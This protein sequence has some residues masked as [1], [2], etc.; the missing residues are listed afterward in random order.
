MGVIVTSISHIITSGEKGYIFL[1]KGHF[2]LNKDPRA[3][4]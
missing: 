1:I 2:T 4:R 3:T